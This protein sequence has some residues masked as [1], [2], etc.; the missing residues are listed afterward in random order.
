MGCLLG[1]NEEIAGGRCNHF[2][3]AKTKEG[4]F[5]YSKS[6]GDWMSSDIFK[7]ERI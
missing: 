4:G 7:K 1:T 5:H 6:P 3:M 2:S